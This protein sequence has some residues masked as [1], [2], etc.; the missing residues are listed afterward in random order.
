MT[1]LW[2]LAALGFAIGVVVASRG[3]FER[4][5]AACV[6]TGKRC[7]EVATRLEHHDARV[8]FPEEPGLYLAL[9]CEGGD[10]EACARAQPWAQRYGDYEVFELDAG[11]M[12]AG[13]PFACEEV[14]TALHGD[15]DD[16][17]ASAAI[18]AIVRS[19][20]TR[21]LKLYLARC[22]AD[23]Q[24]CLG[25]SRVYAAGYGVEWD[26]R[27]AERF[28]QR[29]C[30]LGSWEACELAGDRVTGAVAVALY[31]RAC[32]HHAPHACRKLA[33]L[34]TGSAAMIADQRACEQLS[35]E[36][37][38]ALGLTTLRGQSAAVVDAFHRWCDSGEAA[39]CALLEGA[40]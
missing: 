18:A 22:G 3:S 14:A 31:R 19:R 37:C 20:M 40:R 1:R 9:A 33:R 7:A 35:F 13:N 10:R 23:A 25:A 32:D 29:A 30:A 28:A 21:A 5:R 2:L 39:A 38:A 24:A 15:S 11:C 8:L 27:A 4:A 17:V 16:H 12:I 6:A 36:G 34:E 26:L